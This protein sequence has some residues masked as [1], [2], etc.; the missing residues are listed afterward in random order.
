MRIQLLPLAIFAAIMAPVVPLPAQQPVADQ[1][2]AVA[3]RI[4]DAAVADSTS[5]GA[6][7]RRSSTIAAHDLAGA[8]TWNAA[9]TGCWPK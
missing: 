3:N 9:S 6:V 8:P 7:W 4:I 5:P 1:Y 2:R